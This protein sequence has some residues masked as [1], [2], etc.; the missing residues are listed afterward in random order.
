MKMGKTTEKLDWLYIQT[1]K[2]RT[3]LTIY[4][5]GCKYIDDT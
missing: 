2:L 3:K 1:M 5:E 4:I